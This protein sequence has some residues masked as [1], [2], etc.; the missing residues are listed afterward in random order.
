MDIDKVPFYHN[1]HLHL[2]G[3][4]GSVRVIS[5]IFGL[6]MASKSILDI[7]I[8]FNNRGFPLLGLLKPTPLLG[9]IDT[10]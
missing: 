6:H 5:H 8:F 9:F 10:Y 2:L 4:G 7:E 1:P 3:W